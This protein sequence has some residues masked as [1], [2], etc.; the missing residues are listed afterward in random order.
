MATKQWTA[1]ELRAVAD[2]IDRKPV[3]KRKK[4]RINTFS[5]LVM[6]GIM[7]MFF[8]GAGLGGYV[9][10]VNGEPVSITLDYIMQLAKIVALGYFVKAFGENIAKIVLSAKFKP[11]DEGGLE[12]NG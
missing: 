7:V 4:K 11:I 6:A 8:A 12:D 3:R 10:I 9:T 2:S 1:D 5:H